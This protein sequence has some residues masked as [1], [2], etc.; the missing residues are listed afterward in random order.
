MEP[1]LFWTC[2]ALW[3]LLWGAL[4]GALGAR[5]GAAGTAFVGGLLVGPLALLVVAI[6]RGNMRECEACRKLVHPKATICPSC[7]STTESVAAA[8]E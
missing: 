4:A 6:S 7:R 2:Y 8:V 3:A 5:K 1:T